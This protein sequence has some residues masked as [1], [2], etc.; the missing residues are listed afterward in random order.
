[1]KKKMRNKKKKK[2]KVQTLKRIAGLLDCPTCSGKKPSTNRGVRKSFMK[3]RKGRKGKRKGK[4]GNCDPL[5]IQGLPQK[6]STSFRSAKRMRR[7]ENQTVQ[8]RGRGKGGGVKVKRFR[9]GDPLTGLGGDTLG[10]GEEGCRGM[11]GERGEESN[12]Q[13]KWVQPKKREKKRSQKHNN[14]K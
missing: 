14:G 12:G 9:K 3:G 1:M 13:G 4:G 2:K 7:R 10:R 5:K 8:K 6:V 11:V